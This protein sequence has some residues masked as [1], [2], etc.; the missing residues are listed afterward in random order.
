MYNKL[1]IVDL[2]QSSKNEIKMIANKINNTD[3]DVGIIFGDPHQSNYLFKKTLYYVPSIHSDSLEF[4]DRYF[5]DDGPCRMIFIDIEQIFYNKINDPDSEYDK[6]FK[7]FG[8]ALITDKEFIIISSSISPM[9]VFS[10]NSQR[11]VTMINNKKDCEIIYISANGLGYHAYT[12]SNINYINCPGLSN[13]KYYVPKNPDL[14]EFDSSPGYITFDMNTFDIDFRI[15]YYPIHKKDIHCSIIKVIELCDYMTVLL[16]SADDNDY[17]INK[18]YDLLHSNLKYVHRY[19]DCLIKLT[20]KV[21]VT[22]KG[23]LLKKVL[24][25]QFGLS[26]NKLLERMI[27]QSINVNKKYGNYIKQCDKL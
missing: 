10:D 12:L 3:S 19:I 22:T 5:I 8:D 27:S 13:I 7:W 14:L 23:D 18:Y 25:R 2:V 20:P 15:I 9:D 1:F 6:F 16:N 11:F 24:K 17:M 21:T 26:T 4:I